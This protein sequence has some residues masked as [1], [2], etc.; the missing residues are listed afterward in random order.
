M[1]LVKHSLVYQLLLVDALTDAHR[2]TSNNASDT[3]YNDE[4]S[5]GYCAGCVDT[6]LGMCRYSDGYCVDLC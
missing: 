2:T 4:Y 6:V 3:G 1:S 5:A